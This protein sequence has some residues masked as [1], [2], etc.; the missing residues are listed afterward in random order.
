MEQIAINIM[1]SFAILGIVALLFLQFSPA[2]Y[3][4]TKAANMVVNKNLRPAL[5]GL[6]LHMLST[7]GKS[8]KVAFYTFTS[9]SVIIALAG[10]IYE[11]I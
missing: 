10:Y 9:V 8:L 7:Y 3:T 11:Q 2:K 6:P 1:F 4:L 5:W